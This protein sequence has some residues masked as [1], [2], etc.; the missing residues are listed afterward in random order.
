[1]LIQDLVSD[2]A[3]S[4]IEDSALELKNALIASFETAIDRRLPPPMAIA[5]ILE[6]VSEECFRLQAS[7]TSN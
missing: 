6:W 1:M 5:T 2:F 7:V 3:R 4:S